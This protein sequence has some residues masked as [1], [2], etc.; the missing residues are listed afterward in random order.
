[1]PYLGAEPGFLE[2]ANLVCLRPD[3][4]GYWE[5]GDRALLAAAGFHAMLPTLNLAHRLIVSHFR[6]RPTKG[7][8]GRPAPGVPPTQWAPPIRDLELKE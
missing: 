5:V 2:R 7:V 4:F 3:D 8:W 6:G 1:V